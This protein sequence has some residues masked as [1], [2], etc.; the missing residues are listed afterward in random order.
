MHILT[1]KLTAIMLVLNRENHPHHHILHTQRKSNAMVD[2]SSDLD[3]D[4]DRAFVLVLSIIYFFI[5]LWFG[6]SIV[7]CKCDALRGGNTD[8]FRFF[9]SQ[10]LSLALL[11]IFGFAL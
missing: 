11:T 2:S 9:A 7:V 10:R 1:D 4:F 8:R 3:T 6:W 5:A